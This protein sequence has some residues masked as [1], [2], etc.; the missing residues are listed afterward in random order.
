MKY[1]ILPLVFLTCIK[2]SAQELDTMKV[3]NL[4]K[5]TVSAQSAR[6]YDSMLYYLDQM[7]EVNEIMEREDLYI[8]GT[9]LKVFALWRLKDFDQADDVVLQLEKLFEKQT[10]IKPFDFGRMQLAKARIRSHR[11]EL[12]E[13]RPLFKGALTEFL[14][15]NTTEAYL[16]QGDMYNDLG[17]NAAR[18]AEYGLASDYLQK[19]LVVYDSLQNMG[20]VSSNHNNLGNLYQL[21]GSYGMAADHYQKALEIKKKT[22]GEWHFS[23][24]FPYSNLS[25]LYAD[26]GM[27]N[28]ALEYQIMSM[29]VAMKN[30]GEEN[31]GYV[32]ENIGLAISYLT[33]EDFDNALKLILRAEEAAR[34]LKN[35]FP[36]VKGDLAYIRAVYHA[37]IGEFELGADYFK[38]SIA[39]YEQMDRG[40]LEKASNAKANFGFRYA[41]IGELDKAIDYARQAIADMR[42]VK[43][44]K[45]WA[46]A[47]AY[48]NIAEWTS[49]KGDYTE[50][51]LAINKA[52]D[53][54]VLQYNNGIPDLSSVV[55]RNELLSAMAIKGNLL[56]E[57]FVKSQ[58]NELGREAIIYYQLCDSLVREKQETEAFSDQL[59]LLKELD[60]VYDQLVATYHHF[61]A[62]EGKEGDFRQAFYYA[63]RGNS[64]LLRHQEKQISD[65]K[66]GRVSDEVVALERQL[67][68]GVSYLK[69]QIFN[70]ENTGENVSNEQLNSLKIR[71]FNKNRSLDS[72]KSEL[73]ERYPTYF[74]YMYATELPTL[75][76][77]EEIVDKKSS[78]IQY[79]TT[80]TSIYAFKFHKGESQ[81]VKLK[82]EDD[83][84]QNLNTCL[85]ILSNPVSSLESDFMPLATALYD[86]LI[87]PL[88]DLNE[89]IKILADGALSRLP[90]ET[91][92]DRDQAGTAIPYVI[93]KHNV[94]YINNISQLTQSQ[95]EPKS[96]RRLKVL[97]IAPDYTTTENAPDRELR[98]SLGKL[99]Y[100]V[101]EVEALK[102][103]YNTDIYKKGNATE[104]SFRLNSANK[105][106]LHIAS[107]A[108]V[109][110]SDPLSS[111]IVFEENKDDSLNDGSLFVHELYNLSLD[112][113]LVVLS[114]CNT[115]S[116]ELA[117]GEG[118]LSLGR[119]FQYAGVRS[120]VLSHWQV[121]DQSTSS[122]MTSFHE[123]LVKGQTKSDALR[124]AKL[125]Y[126]AN[127]SNLTAHPFFWG[128]FVVIGDDAPLAGQ[129]N[130]YMYGLLI[131]ILVLLFYL[132]K[133]VRNRN[134]GQ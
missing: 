71:L 69:S 114:A 13:A 67:K 75:S 63:N 48:S 14:K 62:E 55:H 31:D 93:S 32:E 117:D 28:L 38:K 39:L 131:A 106:I 3:K 52:I 46:V 132:F 90:F 79:V 51:I 60:F 122:I 118:I 6:Q 8:E 35:I 20:K 49:R 127:A 88:G 27:S 7:L 65:R 58:N 81:F 41:K 103:L 82:L 116:G 73:E 85:E 130:W 111:R 113:D 22:L 109:N 9:L 92:A 110:S 77:I 94:S 16:L 128:A 64:V 74:N 133:I 37:D 23:L 43:G 119:G 56:K 87:R 53:A 4:L 86:Q 95:P 54:T 66:F 34:K 125:E 124:N 30:D 47:M 78:F 97:A 50:S 68:E 10:Q 19:S 18:M 102:D 112:A 33:L 107:H 121:N 2:T 70:L 101:A 129:T 105:N 45:S 17:I 100:T 80:A 40:G 29:N 57:Q 120:V 98:S 26:L 89:D 108:L 134:R 123:N 91:L 5:E 96:A 59:D 42:E 104:T 1:F 126:I 84:Y 76:Q 12:K 44:D 36:I 83:F 15:V 61:Y 11:G 115:G 21:M 25:K 72:L 24:S 99:N